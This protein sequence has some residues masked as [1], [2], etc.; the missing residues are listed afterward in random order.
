[1]QRIPDHIK[2]EVITAVAQA[3][4]E[5]LHI[6]TDGAVP[7]WEHAPKMFLHAHLE[8]TAEILTPAWPI[9]EGHLNQEELPWDNS[10]PETP[11]SP[12]PG[13]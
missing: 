5:K 11:A 7:T 1:M 8:H 13:T 3:S 2:A 4:V 9:I 12:S 10:S 6:S